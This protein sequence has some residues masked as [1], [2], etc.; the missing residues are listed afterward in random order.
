MNAGI[1]LA[2]LK[3]PIDGVVACLSTMCARSGKHLLTGVEL[4]NLVSLSPSEDEIK[5]VKGFKGDVKRLG[6]AEKFFLAVADVPA[7]RARAQGLLY[8]YNFDDRVKEARNRVK[9]FAAAIAQIRGADRFQRLL[10][11]V[12]VLGNKMNGIDKEHRKGIVK[13][14]T[15]N[16]LHQLAITKTFGDIPVTVLSYFIKLLKRVDPD[17]LR[18]SRDFKGSVLAEAKRL[19]LDVMASEMREMREGLTSV[20]AM[21]RE[22]AQ[23]GAGMA[24][25]MA[26][27][28][29]P[30]TGGGPQYADEEVEVEGAAGGGK[31]D[32]GGGNT[33][34]SPAAAGGGGGGGG[35]DGADGGTGTP[36]DGGESGKAKKTKKR[37]RRRV[38]PLPAF[39]SLAQ[40][41]LGGLQTEFD[42]AQGQYKDLVR[43]F[44][45]DGEMGA[46]EL[47]GNIHL[48]IQT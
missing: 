40:T 42:A 26:S 21:V 48:F 17:L 9:L 2:K 6:P 34:A 12:L 36:A 14:F 39:A 41:E 44:K 27:S 7:C 22:A 32:A 15:V 4:Q 47:F 38:E 8:Q 1:A 20:E 13:A 30:G 18:L 35:G 25:V 46:D 10:K 16:S 23:G 33:N 24:G 5:L 37:I 3:M 45:E 28:S 31:G 43:F 29:S 19:P 11:A